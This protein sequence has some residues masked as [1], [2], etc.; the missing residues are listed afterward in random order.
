MALTDNIVAYWKL[1]ESSGN[2]AD[3][4]GGQTLTNNNTV[5]FATGKINNAADFSATN[6][7]KSLTR[8]DA[9]GIGTGAYTQTAWYNPS[10]AP[11]ANTNFQ[12]FD[13]GNDANNVTSLFYYKDTAGT[14]SIK[15]ERVRDGVAA[16]TITD[17]VTLSNGTWYHLAVTFDTSTITAYRNA[18]VVGAVASSGDGSAGTTLGTALGSLVASAGQFN[19][20][21]IDEVGLWT[22]ALSGAEITTVYNGGVGLQYPFSASLATRKALLGVGI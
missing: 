12:I 20:G 1:D 18:S 10:A 8:T 14:K 22:R 19:S 13:V 16:N 5:G 7:D 6:T 15:Y 9:S 11:A 3:A 2:A 4:V 17:T 21:L